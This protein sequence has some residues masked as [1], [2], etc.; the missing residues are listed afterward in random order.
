MSAA[1]L[2]GSAPLNSSTLA[3]YLNSLN[4]GMDRTFSAAATSCSSSTSTCGDRVAETVGWRDGWRVFSFTKI[5][6]KVRQSSAVVWSACLTYEACIYKDSDRVDRKCQRNYCFTLS[7]V[8]S[9]YFGDRIFMICIFLV[10]CVFF[11]FF[12]P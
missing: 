10:H 9:E 8:G 7:S 3:P 2:L 11:V 4:V 1:S 12:L 6:R 5:Q